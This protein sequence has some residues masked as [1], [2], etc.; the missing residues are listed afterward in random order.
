MHKTYQKLTPNN[1][2]LKI[3][4]TVVKMTLVLKSGITV[5]EKLKI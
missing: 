3:Q 4:F 2:Q 5:G 1:Q